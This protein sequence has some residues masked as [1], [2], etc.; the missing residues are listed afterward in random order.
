[1]RIAICP[2]K[3]KGSLS[4]LKVAGALK[5]GFREVYPDA[6]YHLVPIADGG[7]GTAEIF[8]NELAGIWK[9][10]STADALGRNVDAAYGWIPSE[11]LAVIEMST[12]AGLWRLSEDELNPLV[13][14]TYGVGQ[15]IEEATKT[16]A[17]TIY[18]GL[19]GSATNDAG[20][21][22][23]A[24][25]GWK[26]LNSRC[27]EINPTPGQFL[28]IARI[29]PPKAPLPIKVRGLCDVRNPLLGAEGAT[30]VYG[31]QKGASPEVVER[32]EAALA[33]LAD[34]CARDLGQDFRA[35]PGSGA[36]GGL[37]FGLLTFCGAEIVSGF[38]AIEE[39]LHLADHIAAADLVITGEGRIDRQSLHGKGPAE[40]ARL[41]R[42]HGKPVIAFA[43]AS[44][45]A[46][47]VFDAI[48][49]IADGPLTL[50]E[51]RRRAADLLQQAAV[52]TARLLKIAL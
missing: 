20:V 25:I 46:D 27:E 52:R 32:L 10:S 42:E 4:A 15:L 41:A 18:V 13:A 30:R 7:E 9:S 49:P 22:L 34:V 2:D 12:A 6:E 35:I 45:V 19:G 1:M 5:A 43:G 31:P 47:G 11:K 26:F 8:V 38:D 14:S 39:L 23:A 3:F 44:E 17:T 51:S 33:H 29:I 36:A 16:G 48:I 37:G 40:I 50:D 24:A 28:E 21:G